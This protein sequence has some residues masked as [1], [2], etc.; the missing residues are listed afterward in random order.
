MS[1]RVRVTLDSDLGL[2]SAACFLSGPEVMPQ[3]C[4]SRPGL[5]GATSRYSRSSTQRARDRQLGSGMSLLRFLSIDDVPSP[6][7]I[8]TEKTV[9]LD[10]AREKKI[11]V[12][13]KKK[14]THTGQ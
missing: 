7:S 2:N 1:Q 10:N 4:Q 14:K 8:S 9:G 11:K 5:A 12:K 6:A 13:S 3:Q